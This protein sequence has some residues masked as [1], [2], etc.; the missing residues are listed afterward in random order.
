MLTELTDHNVHVWEY[1]IGSDHSLDPEVLKTVIKDEEFAF[2]ASFY[3][4]PRPRF[5]FLISRFNL[6]RVLSQYLEKLPHQIEIKKSSSG[7][8]FLDESDRPTFFS[9]SHS[10]NRGLIAVHNHEQVGC[11]IEYCD[12][13]RIE[14]ELLEVSFSERE[15]SLFEKPVTPES[16]FRRWTLKEA[17]LKAIGQGLLIDPRRIEVVTEGQRFVVIDQG[18]TR[19]NIQLVNKDF[20]YG[21]DRYMGAICVEASEPVS[22]SYLSLKTSGGAR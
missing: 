9:L 16:F 11:D 5:E 7:K 2:A 3:K 21:R 12:A 17:Y 22:V 10:K 8:P 1:E 4:E 13:I 14:P 18:Q 19:P 6:R 20:Q 15:R